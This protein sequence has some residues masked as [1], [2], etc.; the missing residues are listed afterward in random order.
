MEKDKKKLA[1]QD[2]KIRKVL[3]RAQRSNAAKKK[4][5]LKELEGYTKGTI[6]YQ[7]TLNRIK[8]IPTIGDGTVVTYGDKAK[9]ILKEAN[10]KFGIR[11]WKHFKPEHA[12]ELLQDRIDRGL[13]AGTVRQTCHALEYINKHVN[14][15]NVFKKSQKIEITDHQGML[16]KVAENGIVRRAQDSTRLKATPDDC[17][18]VLIEMERYNPRY[19]SIA[20]YE[21]LSG[22]RIN[23]SV[24]Q[25]VMYID[26]KNNKHES[27]KSKGGLN[28]IVYTSHHNDE[29][30]RFLEEIKRCA[31][32]GT[33]RIF[34]RFKNN[35]DNYRSDKLVSKSVS[36]LAKRC[37]NRLGIKGP[38][39]ETFTSH[40]FRGGFGLE[41]ME[42]YA[43]NHERLDEIIKEK[44]EE[45]PRLHTRYKA[46]EG[47]I[48]KKIIK[49]NRDAR[50]IQKEEKIRWLVSTDLNHSRQEVVRFYI[51]NMNVIEALK[52][53]R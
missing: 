25:K 50:V 52:R 31:D 38:R 35:E 9:V 29:D 28:N 51:E 53:H 6:E 30:K 41:R 26:I 11:E 13:V 21:F 20:R 17:R 8:Q 3:K 45:Q 37:A 14:E 7:R 44:I 46:F 16:E 2:K 39:G 19:A 12:K 33:G 36:E 24:K 49:E 1:A 18:R 32:Q 23:D 27:R 42:V 4:E 43:A 5:L 22:F 10:K 47:R 34:E 40:S 15:M 48:R